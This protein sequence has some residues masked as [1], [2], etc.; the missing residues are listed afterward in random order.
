[1]DISKSLTLDDECS[2]TKKLVIGK[3]WGG[4]VHMETRLVD[5][6][7]MLGY[8]ANDV[9]TKIPI[10][11]AVK[12]FNQDTTSTRAA[13]L[14]ESRVLQAIMT[15]PHPYLQTPLE[16]S[17][18]RVVSIMECTDLYRYR[19]EH[20]PMSDQKLF[21][22]MR[23]I[24]MGLARLHEWGYLHLDIK[25]ENILINSAGDALVADIGGYRV[26]DIKDCG[27]IGRPLPE[28]MSA[29][30]KCSDVFGLA[31]L[32]YEHYVEEEFYQKSFDSEYFVTTLKPRPISEKLRNAFFRNGI[33]YSNVVKKLIDTVTDSLSFNPTRRPPLSDLLNAFHEM[34]AYLA[35]PIASPPL[36]PAAA[37]GGGMTSKRNVTIQ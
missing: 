22:A 19:K 8:T 21:E 25:F 2:P 36:E 14:R 16:V 26:E 29:V 15:N 24:A 31:A 9:E 37:R 1:V 6:D 34:E 35:T 18:H 33:K 32:V 27:Y 20:G 7:L 28:A 23:K 17:E 11:V 30:N 3:G 10:R 4:V 13:A 12:T 5:S